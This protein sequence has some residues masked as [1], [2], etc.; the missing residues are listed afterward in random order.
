MHSYRHVDVKQLFWIS[1]DSWR[2]KGSI[3]SEYNH[4]L[5][6]MYKCSKNK[7]TSDRTFQTNSR[8]FNHLVY[9]EQYQLLQI[10]GS[11]NKKAL[12]NF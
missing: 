7:Q 6:N 4:Y 9:V 1:C 11:Q 10:Y 5:G 3:Q 12:D 2:R 8:L